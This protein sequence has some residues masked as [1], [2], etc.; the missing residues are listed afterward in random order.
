[1]F[2]GK[3][4]E[5][6]NKIVEYNLYLV[7]HNGSTFDNYAVLVNVPQCRNI[8]KLIKNEAALVSLNVSN[9]YVDENQKI[10]QYV[11]FRCGGVHIISSLT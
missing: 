4:E 3:S 11:H 1:M 5:V 8:V 7:T 9:G 10:A 2:N 6:K